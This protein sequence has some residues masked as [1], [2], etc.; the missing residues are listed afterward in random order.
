MM[1]RGFAFLLT[2]SA[3]RL[4]ALCATVLFM[5]CATAVAQ[6]S[7]NW[8]VTTLAGTAGQNGSADGTGAAALFNGPRGIAVDASGTIYVADTFN[9]TIRKITSDGS[10]STFAG[11]AGQSGSADGT[12]AGARF[13][14]PAGL[15][16][17]SSGNLYVAD[18]SNNTLR[19]ISSS[20]TVTTLA[21]NP[22]SSGFADGTGTAATFYQPVGVAVDSAGNVYVA[23]SGNSALRK[24]TPSG[25][26][27]TVHLTAGSPPF[28]YPYGV[29]VDGT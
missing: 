5:C 22:A 14:Y 23:D 28:N 9:H 12:G 24:V 18:S 25:T 6:E 13:N 11:V 2:R 27:S 20:G 8:G 29:A 7:A 17:D 10:V 26:D 1:S 4:F 19:K 21:G 15:A 16:I 3:L